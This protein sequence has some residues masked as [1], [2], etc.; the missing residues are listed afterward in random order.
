MRRA[1]VFILASLITTV[2]SAQIV[3]T[4]GPV[5]QLLIPAAGALQGQNG[6]FFRSDITLINYRGAD[7]RVRLQWLPENV[8]G[9]GLAGGD[10]QVQVDEDEDPAGR[11][12][13]SGLAKGGC[14][15]A[16]VGEQL[17]SALGEQEQAAFMLRRRATHHMPV[18]RPFV[19]RRKAAARRSHIGGLALIQARRC[20]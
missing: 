5:P 20:H 9:V 17:H 19:H 6:T 3:A 10:D 15:V 16:V 14:D 18:S 8:T 13:R 7:Q 4:R 12:C 1:I 2:A 11:R